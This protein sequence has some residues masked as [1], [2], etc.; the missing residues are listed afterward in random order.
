MTIFGL[1]K[2]LALPP[3]FASI[4]D[5]SCSEQTIIPTPLT[6]PLHHLPTLLTR[7]CSNEF[8]SSKVKFPIDPYKYQTIFCT[9]PLPP[10]KIY[11][12]GQILKQPICK[13]TLA[14]PT[15]EQQLSRT[16]MVTEPVGT[17]DF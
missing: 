15:V 13:S 17:G 16:V 11:R 2:A 8:P 10:L 14:P 4:L 12:P 9:P 7:F 5:C 1:P 3:P 6:N